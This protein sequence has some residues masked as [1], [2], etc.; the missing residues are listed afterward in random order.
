MAAAGNH[1]VG[2]AREH[3]G[4]HLVES[5]AAGAPYLLVG[6]AVEMQHRGVEHREIDAELV[7]PGPQQ[8]GQ[9]GRGAVIGV[10]RGVAP[11]GNAGE[12]PVEALGVGRGIIDAAFGAELMVALDHAAAAPLL[13]IF[14]EERIV[15][16]RVAVAVDDGMI[17][18]RPGFRRAGAT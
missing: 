11:I 16:N 9:H 10:A 15:L 13:E 5:P 3:V 2:M 4:P 12:A 14:E 6:E 8:L 18:T 17:E 1:A 7:E